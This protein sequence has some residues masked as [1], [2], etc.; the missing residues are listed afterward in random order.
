MWLSK[1]DKGVSFFSGTMG[2]MR[3]IIFKNTFKKEGSNEPDYE[4]YFEEQKK[5]DTQEVTPKVKNPLDDD[6]PF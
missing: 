4:M 1:S 6:I 5:K 2:S 3:V